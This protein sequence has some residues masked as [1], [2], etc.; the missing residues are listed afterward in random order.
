LLPDEL[1]PSLLGK[2]NWRQRRSPL[3]T[4]TAGA[5]ASAALA[6]GV[7]VALAGHAPTSVSGSSQVSESVQPMAPLGTNRLASK[8]TLSSYGWGTSIAMDCVCLAPLNAGHDTLAMV[9]VGRDGS[10]TRLATWVADPGHTATPAGSISMH[11]DQIASVQVVSAES[12]QVLLEHS[13]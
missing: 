6:I 9:V 10:H 7:L 3:V 12:G 1:L 5:A 4:W 8:V 2:V 13:R 11:L